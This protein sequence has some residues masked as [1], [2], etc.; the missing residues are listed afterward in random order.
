[1]TLMPLLLSV[2][3]SPSFRYELH[4]NYQCDMFFQHLIIIN[5]TCYNSFQVTPGTKALES[6]KDFQGGEPEAALDY[7]ATD[8]YYASILPPGPSCLDSPLPTLDD[9]SP[10]PACKAIKD[11]P[12][13]SVR[14][15]G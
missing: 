4:Q 9:E 10:R 7:D 12:V 1:M 11:E 14:T 15:S 5:M 8:L 6:F 3:H 2:Q 13:A